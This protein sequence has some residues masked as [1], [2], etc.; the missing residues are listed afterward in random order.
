[1][2]R[3]I[4]LPKIAPNPCTVVKSSMFSMILH[5]LRTMLWTPL[6]MPKRSLIRAWVRIL[7]FGVFPKSHMVPPIR[8]SPYTY[9]ACAP[10]KPRVK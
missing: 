4:V 7:R 6:S 5:S 3:L 1:M 8:P 10:F 2:P 9:N